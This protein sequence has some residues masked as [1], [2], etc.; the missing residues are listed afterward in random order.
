MSTSY[1]KTVKT[2]SVPE[3]FLTCDE[4]DN[5][6]NTQVCPRHLINKNVSP[7]VNSKRKMKYS[8]PHL[9]VELL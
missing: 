5:I 3:H 8:K 7:H 6:P 4:E 9:T 1:N 2:Q